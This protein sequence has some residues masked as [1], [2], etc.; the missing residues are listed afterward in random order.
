MGLAC[1]VIYYVKQKP[2]FIVRRDGSKGLRVKIGSNTVLFVY[3]G[4]SK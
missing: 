3:T 1:L 4:I 2:D